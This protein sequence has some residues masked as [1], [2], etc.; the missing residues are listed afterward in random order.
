[1]PPPCGTGRPP[2][3][4]TAFATRRSAAGVRSLFGTALAELGGIDLLVNNMGG[5]SGS[6]VGFHDAD[7][8]VWTRAFEINVLSTVRATR[9][10]LPSRIERRGAIVNVSSISALMPD[11]FP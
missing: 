10:V 5:G 7:D 11:A 4:G 8:A 1:M 2:K 9:A 6:S 3:G